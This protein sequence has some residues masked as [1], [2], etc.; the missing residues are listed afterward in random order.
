MGNQEHHYLNVQ[1]YLKKYGIENLE[2]DLSIQY[3]L[4]NDVMILN[5]NS[6]ESPKFNPIS[7]EC[8]GLILD[9]H[10][11]NVLSKG[12]KRFYND[13]EIPDVNKYDFSKAIITEKL[14]GTYISVWWDPYNNK[15]Q[16]STRKCAYNEGTT[17]NTSKMF[18]ELVEIA[19]GDPN[20]RFDGMNKDLTYIFELVSPYSRIITPYYNTDMYLLSVI[21]R[22]IGFEFPFD[23]F[24]KEVAEV[25]DVERPKRMSFSTLGEIRKT[26]E[27]VD[28][29]YEGYVCTFNTND[30]GM[31]DRVRTKNKRYIE[32]VVLSEGLTR[33][34]RRII[35]NLINGNYIEIIEVM[36]ELKKYFDEAAV[37]KRRLVEDVER[38]W[39][40]VKF[41]EDKGEFARV[42]ISKY[43]KYQ[44]FLFGLKNGK[45]IDSVLEKMSSK[46]RANMIG[47]FL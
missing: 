5:Y 10:N 34:N 33:S 24:V 38:C 19:I 17:L 35:D 27:E 37:A 39:E 40:N 14:D 32:M 46:V 41:I 2:K 31:Y 44:G 43:N 1:T 4:Y 30:E 47:E 28:T 16:T 22:N 36:P 21:E 23:G 8:R 29:C 25:L 18:K 26:L 6:H 13:F 7:D 42:V 12:F 45:S 9:R 3:K 20:V 11:L 15:W